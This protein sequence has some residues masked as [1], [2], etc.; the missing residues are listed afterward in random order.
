MPELKEILQQADESIKFFEEILELDDCMDA[1][2]WL[3]LI[4]AL[5]DELRGKE[6]MKEALTE[7][8]KCLAELKDGARGHSETLEIIR[9][10][11][12][13]ALKNNPEDK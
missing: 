2:H 11:T 1:K 4:K 5:A 6:K 7:T 3:K 12:L 9:D 10:V 8:Q 13:S